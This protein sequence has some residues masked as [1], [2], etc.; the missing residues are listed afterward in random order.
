MQQVLSNHLLDDIKSTFYRQTMF[1]EFELIVHTQVE[2][3]KPIGLEFYRKIYRELLEKYFGESVSI[4]ETD[5]LEFLRIPHFYSAF[6]VY[7]YAT[8][9]SAAIDISH[10]IL[11]GDK[12]ST[13]C[14][15]DFLASGG[16]KHPLELLRAAGVDLE[17]KESLDSTS[18]LFKEELERFKG[19]INE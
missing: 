13:Q 1:A 4:T 3:R 5:E 10:R 17:K 9:L 8:G 7:K 6:Y 11:A 2:E 19:L 14:Y 18:K 12:K 15:L 16:S